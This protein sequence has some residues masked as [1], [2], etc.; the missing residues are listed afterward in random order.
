MW[1]PLSPEAGICGREQ[2]EITVETEGSRD[3]LLLF[4]LCF[5][6]CL[7]FKI[8]TKQKRAIF[9]LAPRATTSGERD[10]GEGFVDV[11]RCA[12]RQNFKR[13]SSPRPSPPLSWK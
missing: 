4:G 8:Q 6:R 9:S 3:F 5:L 13:S 12:L 10:R 1:C 11:P 2:Q 7:L